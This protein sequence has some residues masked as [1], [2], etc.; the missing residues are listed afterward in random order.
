MFEKKLLRLST[1]ADQQRLTQQ[2]PLIF[3]E[4]INC[5][6]SWRLFQVREN[7]GK[8]GVSGSEMEIFLKKLKLINYELK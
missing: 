5:T 8:T 1:A 4:K 7:I 3:F 6:I 2:L